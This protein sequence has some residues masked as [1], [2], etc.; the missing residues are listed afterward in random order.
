[1]YFFFYSL[2]ITKRI[3]KD[4]IFHTWIYLII[5]F[6]HSA[7]SQYRVVYHYDCNMH[8]QINWLL[9]VL[10]GNFGI[11]VCGFSWLDS[12]S[13]GHRGG[14]ATRNGTWQIMHWFLARLKI[15][16]KTELVQ[17][18]RCHKVREKIR[19]SCHEIASVLVPTFGLEH[20]TLG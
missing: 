3:I 6:L 4:I 19:G 8:L 10:T 9:V 16:D 5:N 7:K 12:T 18:C 20:Y 13:S 17:Y 15:E 14:N 11:C 2:N 1:M